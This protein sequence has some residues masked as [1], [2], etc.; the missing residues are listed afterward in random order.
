MAA[1]DDDD[2]YVRYANIPIPSY[3]E[4]TASRSGSS[5]DARENSEREGLLNE[6][7]NPYQHPSVESART[8]LATDD[9]ED[10]DLR[11][12]EVNR[13]D[14]ER[15]QVEELDY[16]DPSSPDSSRRSPRLYHRVR[17]RR[18]KWTQQLSNIGASLSAIRLPNLSL[19]SLYR[20]V[21]TTEEGEVQPDTRTWLT[22]FSSRA[23]VPEQYRVSAPTAARLAGLATLLTFIY[24]LFAFDI[25][26]GSR[27][28]M[29]TRFDPEAIRRFVQEHVDGGNIRST[30]EHITSFDHVAGT[31]GDLYLARWM[32]ER[33]LEQD[34]FDQVA[35]LP[36]HVYLDYPGERK[37][38][39]VRPEGKRWTAALE[40][41]RVFPDRQQ[42]GAWHGHSR[43]GDVEGHLIYANG[44][45]KDDFAWLKE[46]GIVTNGSI[47]LVLYGASQPD[48]AL[49]IHAAA[50]AGC[51]GVLMYSSPSNVA[52]DSAWKPS[53]DMV[54]RN[55]VAM[56]SWVLGDP[57]TPGWG[58]HKDGRARL[59]TGA[60]P[61]LPSIPSLPLAWR[62]AKVLLQ[63]LDGF[64]ASVPYS[65]V[66][67]PG[68]GLGKHWFSGA[69]DHGDSLVVHL[70]NMNEEN[71]LQEIWNLHGMFEGIEQPQSKIIVGSHR[72]AWCFGAVDPGSGSAV[73]MEVIRIFAELKRLNWR[74][75]RTIEFVSWDAEEYN[76]IGSTEYVEDNAK[77]LRDNAVAYLNV[78]AGVF[79]PMFTASGSP[80]WQRTLDHVL[81]RVGDP[82]SNGSASLRQKWNEH[83][84]AFNPLGVDGDFAALQDIAGTS[85]ISFGFV[86]GL[87]ADAEYYPYHSCHETLEWMLAY[88][89]STPDFAYHKALAQVW[90]LL[91][92]DLADRPLLPFDVR[93]YAEKLSV[94][95]QDLERSAAGLWAKK[96][97]LQHASAGDLRAATGFDVAPLTDA[98]TILSQQAAAFHKF[99]DTW[100]ANVLGAGGLETSSFAA[101]RIEYNNRLARFET[102][103]LDLQDNAQC[104]N[105]GGIPGRCQYKH[106][107]F[108]P[109]RDGSSG[110]FPFVRDAM[111]D[112][113]WE[114]AGVWVER[115]AG[116][117]GEAGRRL[118]EG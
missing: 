90:A 111:E 118:M 114:K 60:A 47:A 16:L 40:E 80:L 54:Q 57:L 81:D 31:E 42:L 51:V 82:G 21:E 41:D 23:S 79:G 86:K 49:K 102:E 19:R 84:Q 14:I 77:F 48:P 98:I 29:G 44:G 92:L 110:L 50:E 69:S 76:M 71:P 63:G 37:V 13:E 17:L 104:P 5:Q 108:G 78:D 91:I 64:G 99:E 1:S 33:W 116:R 117:V 24:F 18:G 53:D 56:T 22:R 39:V 15:R 35:M 6:A 46:N 101:R 20:P 61:G 52:G 65:W 4:A 62:D 58:S 87:G 112:G 30:L 93:T 38:E 85:S 72:D 32:E 3:D 9:D 8:S 95:T 70:Q 107:V 67:W 83:A 97:G 68:D 75:L 43:S 115:A 36:Y 28:G 74:P 34:L 45:H 105:G 88:G 106:V 66:H 89:D 113:E 55:G 103:L 94:W 2:K 26:P 7:R 100:T 10:D 59:D 27:R 73:M 12:P 25:F 11:L 96:Q 109:S